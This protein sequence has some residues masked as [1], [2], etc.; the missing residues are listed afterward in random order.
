LPTAVKKKSLPPI[1][2]SPVSDPKS[3]AQWR[4]AF[5][6][7]RSQAAEHAPST[8]TTFTGIRI[9]NIL[10]M[11]EAD[12]DIRDIARSLAMQ[13]RWGG[14]VRHFFSVAEHCVLLSRFAESRKIKKI[15]LLHDASEAYF[16]EIPK[17]I[18]IAVPAIR[19]AEQRCHQVICS[20]FGLPWPW[21]AIVKKYDNMM[22]RTESHAF[23]TVD[24]DHPFGY[25]KALPVKIQCWN[26]E[27]AEDEFLHD[28]NKL[29]DR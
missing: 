29:W 4:K 27:R 20:R 23:R 5:K 25:P 9:L 19:E 28:F 11:V 13:C 12:V 7:T 22:W 17:P 6:E 21:P 16:R 18:K 1:L 10:N 3:V 26:P 2:S 14:H 15:L 24:V 8:M